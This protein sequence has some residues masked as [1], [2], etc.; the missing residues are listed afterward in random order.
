MARVKTQVSVE[1]E[2]KAPAWYAEL[3][4]ELFPD[5]WREFAKGIVRQRLVEVFA[6]NDA[7]LVRATNQAP[8]V[9]VFFDLMNERYFP[10]SDFWYEW[11]CMAA[12]EGD[13]YCWHE[14][15]VSTFF[16]PPGDIDPHDLLPV[17]QTLATLEGEVEYH[18]ECRF[19]D[20]P[21]RTVYLVAA[22]E[23]HKVDRRML[24]GLC[25][26][27]ASPLR[28]L[29]FSL[30]VMNQETGNIWFDYSDEMYGST[31]CDWSAETVRALK[32]DF[33]VASK[34]ADRVLE[35]DKWLREDVR[36][37]RDASALW[38]RCAA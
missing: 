37:V 13:E 31:G 32:R 24:A 36:R 14:I 6:E 4:R 35:L 5:V 15:P 11:V 9:E 18:R 25:R 2:S 21:L 26:R 17:F 16:E 28:H 30:E 33:D 10:L 8:P 29:D 19:K 1:T 23:L 3:F 38:R 34:Q 22:N 7:E 20:C 12:D 27:E